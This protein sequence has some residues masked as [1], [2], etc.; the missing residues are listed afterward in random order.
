[1][2]SHTYDTEVLFIFQ[3]TDVDGNP[4]IAADNQM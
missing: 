2:R 4:G 3:S 1:M